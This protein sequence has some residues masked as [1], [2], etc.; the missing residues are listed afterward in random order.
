MPVYKKQEGID[1]SFV[2][3]IKYVLPLGVY[4][5]EV[6]LIMEDMFFLLSR[7]ATDTQ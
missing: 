3:D 5:E 6:L 1:F 2:K 4:R 7:E